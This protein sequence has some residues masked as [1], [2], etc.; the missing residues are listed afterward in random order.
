MMRRILILL[1]CIAPLTASGCT[2]AAWQAWKTDVDETMKAMAGN[3]Q[4]L[5]ASSEARDI[6]RSLSSHR[7]GK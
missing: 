4:Y 7:G 5:G 6:E 3:G 2:R 1:A